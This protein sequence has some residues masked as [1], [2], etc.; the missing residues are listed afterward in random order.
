MKTLLQTKDTVLLGLLLALKLLLARITS[1]SLGIVRIGFGFIATGLIGFLY[2]PVISF[3]TGALGD[4]LGFFLFPSGG[5]YFPG[6][7][8]TSALSGFIYGKV[9]YGKK[10]TLPRMLLACGLVCCICNIGLNTLWTSILY[11]KAFLALLPARLLKN[12]IVIPINATVLFCLLKCLVPHLNKLDLMFT[13]TY[14][15]L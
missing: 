10:I 14:K 5:N 1:I 15:H 8:L 7:T 11:N 3:I 9:L 6:Y 13:R 4:L 12:L 2:G